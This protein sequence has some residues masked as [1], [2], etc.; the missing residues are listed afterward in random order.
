VQPVEAFRI[1]AGCGIAGEQSIEAVENI[2]GIDD[3]IGVAVRF[4]APP[5]M[6]AI[7]F[8]AQPFPPSSLRLMMVRLPPLCRC[9]R[10]WPSRPRRG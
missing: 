6:T 4:A 10:S 5:S 8:C 3:E 2:D 9:R 7:S 1:L